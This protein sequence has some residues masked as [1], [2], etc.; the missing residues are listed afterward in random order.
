[1]LEPLE[2]GYRIDGDV[3]LVC[4][5]RVF[6]A[7]PA[8]GIY[9]LSCLKSGDFDSDAFMTFVEKSI[10]NIGPQEWTKGIW[11]SQISGSKLIVSASAMAHCEIELLLAN[12]AQQVRGSRGEDS[13][14]ARVLDLRGANNESQPATTQ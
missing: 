3:L 12:L 8:F 5:K 4:S 7:S 1:M 6:N 13:N 9:D 2:L 11:E 14:S 10:R